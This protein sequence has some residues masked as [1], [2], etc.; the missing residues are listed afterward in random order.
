MLVDT[1]R[2]D[3]VRRRAD[4]RLLVLAALAVVAVATYLLIDVRG[5]WAF[6]L[7]LR[8][9]TILTMLLVGYAVAVSTVLFQT[10]ATNRILTPSIMGFDALYAL[11]QTALVAAL[12]AASLTRVPTAAQFALEVGLMVGFSQPLHE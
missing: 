4:R 12:G 6:A 9:W 3:P 10:V 2:T 5:S 8:G 11:I 7:R 1:L